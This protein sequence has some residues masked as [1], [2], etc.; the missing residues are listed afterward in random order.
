MNDAV[1]RGVA[2]INAAPYGGGILVKGQTAQPKYAYRPAPG[3][4]L[5]RVS[6]LRDACDRHG[7]PLAA[8]ALQFSLRDAR[9]TSTVVG[10]SAPERIDQT[11]RLAS[12]PIPDELWEDIS[13]I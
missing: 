7:V 10:M 9:V 11:L 3:D 6:S 4:L 5:E 8:A 2:F 13:K 1:A 12:W